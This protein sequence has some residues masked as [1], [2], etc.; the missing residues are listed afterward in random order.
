LD[1]YEEVKAWLYEQLPMYQIEGASAYKPGLDKIEAFMAYLG[2]PHKDFSSIHVAGTNGKGSTA[3]MITSVLMEA[4]YKVGLY[5]SPHI[6]DFTERIR[7][8]GLV[9]ETSFIVKFVQKHKSYFTDSKLSFFELTVGIAFQYF[10][11][12]NIEYAVVEVG[13][14][15]RLDATNIITPILSIITNIGFDHM[16][17]LGNTLVSIAKEKS[18][19]IKKNIPVIIGETQP[20]IVS[21]FNE[22]SSLLKAPII[23]ADT[24]FNDAYVSD[25]KGLYQSKNIQTTVAVFNV[26]NLTAVKK[27]DIAS[28]L[29]RVVHNTNLQGRW[30]ILRNEPFTVADVTHNKAGFTYVVK[31]I[32]NTSIQGIHFVLGFVKYKDLDSIFEILPKKAN[33][34]FSAPN[35]NRAEKVSVLMKLAEKYKLK[36]KAFKSIDLAYKSAVNKAE[37][38]EFI[39]VGGSTFVVAEIL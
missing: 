14:G 35:I 11:D 20:E 28:G 1:S 36:A 9:I 39:Y 27:K 17:F 37:I 30:Q 24:L 12:Q 10:R 5:T 19:I 38:N 22:R 32:K 33:Y 16:Q 8:N 31:Q 21:V 25:L 26:L 6:K 13:L 29:L 34:Y 15:G 2:N 23:W 4:G 3:H 18:G 7:I